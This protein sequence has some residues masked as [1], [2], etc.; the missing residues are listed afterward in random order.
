MVAALVA[1]QCNIFHY[2]YQD[3]DIRWSHAGIN[4]NHSSKT[5]HLQLLSILSRPGLSSVR[6][7]AAMVERWQR[8]T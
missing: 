7:T 2:D 8:M 4:S 6:L 3:K 1:I 5:Y